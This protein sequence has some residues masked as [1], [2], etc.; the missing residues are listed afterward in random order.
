MTKYIQPKESGLFDKA[1]RLEELDQMGDP[2]AR[3][4]EVIDW[5]LFDPVLERLPKVEPK[6]LGGRPPFAPALM[7]KAMVIQN[8]YQLSDQQLE[9]QITD[10]WSFKRFLGLT[11]ADKSPDEKTFWAFRETLTT[12]DLF[13]PLFGIFHAALE[14]KGMFA[15]KGQM[16]DAT[17]VEVPRQRNSREDNAKIKA[18]EVPEG[19]AEH[20][21]K[22]Q[23]KDVDARWTKKNGERY[24][25]YKNHVKVDSRSKLIED[26]TVTAASVHDSQALDELIAKGDPTTYVDSAYTGARCEQIFAE[27]KVLAKPIARAYRNKP[28]NGAQK[29]NNHARSKIR[30][31]VEHV[32]ATMRMSLRAAWNRC[33]G[34]TRNRAM[35]SLTNLVYNL[36]RFEQIERLGLRNWRVA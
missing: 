15:R 22:A 25:G 28:L 10:R 27:K 4:D 9:F 17:F 3:L 6:G 16:V 11:K 26:F 13:E 2:L 7:F 30:V 31:R 12:N 23:Q 8:I 18:G 21:A 36:V 35:I 32:F 14:A 19:W 24:Y 33:V 29:R 34:L 5:T 20:P 1:M